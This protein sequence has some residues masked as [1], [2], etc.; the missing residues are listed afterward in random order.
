MAAEK[1]EQYGK[2]LLAR[3]AATAAKAGMGCSKM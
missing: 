3:F 1:H 2:F